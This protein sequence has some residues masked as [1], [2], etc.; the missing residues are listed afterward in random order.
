MARVVLLLIAI[1]LALAGCG[2]SGGPQPA[3]NAAR[4]VVPATME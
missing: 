3:W 2:D 1:C 4:P